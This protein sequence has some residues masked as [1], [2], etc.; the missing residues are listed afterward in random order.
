VDGLAILIGMVNVLTGPQADAGIQVDNG[1]RLYQRRHCSEVAGRKV[2]FIR[3]DTGGAAPELARRL[4]QDLIARDKVDVL[5]GFTLAPNAVAGAAASAQSRKLMVVMHASGIDTARSPYLVQATA[6]GNLNLDRA[7]VADF[8]AAYG[9]SPD[10]Y[11]VSGYDG[12]H[13]ICEALRRT[14]GN[15]D[16]DALLG[17]VK[18]MRWESPRGPVQLDPESR[19]VVSARR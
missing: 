4:A 19:E 16:A 15:A 5:A 10:G 1:A 11:A 6:S 18:G 3:R 8:Q 9:R 14:G 17:A 2:Q 7:F 13:V 12:M